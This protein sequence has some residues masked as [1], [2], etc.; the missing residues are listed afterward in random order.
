MAKGEIIQVKLPNT[1][2]RK[3]SS[4]DIEIKDR[5]INIKKSNSKQLLNNKYYPLHLKKTYHNFNSEK[6]SF[7]KKIINKIKI[8]KNKINKK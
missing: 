8:F 1:F 3:F 7:L 5:I 2:E 4:L 6:E